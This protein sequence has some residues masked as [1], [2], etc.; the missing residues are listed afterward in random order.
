MA[1]FPSFLLLTPSSFNY[2]G[3]GSCPHKAVLADLDD[4]WDQLVPIFVRERLRTDFVRCI[5]FDPV[6][7]QRIDFLKEYF[8]TRHPSLTYAAPTDE[9]P[10]HA[11]TSRSFEVLLASQV[12]DHPTDDGFLEELSEKV[13]DVGGKLVVQDFSSGMSDQYLSDA[14]QNAFQK[15]HRPDTFKKSILFD[16]TYGEASCS[17]DMS[18]TRP[19]Y[20]RDG[21]FINFAQFKP[22]EMLAI[23]GYNEALDKLT[24]KLFMKKFKTVLDEHHGNYRRRFLGS[25]L[26]YKKPEYDDNSDAAAVMEV[27]QKELNK[28]FEVLLMMGVVTA[29]KHAEMDMLFTNYKKIDMYH[30]NNC[31]R[32]L[33]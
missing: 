15:T 14:F 22:K 3:I 4:A 21:N 29:E 28:V 2:V 6:F 11:W 9:S 31:V 19:V 24:K 12:F 1:S 8:A 7:D 27:L 17:T 5:H 20:D 16:M 26:L 32:K 13:L 33:V 18:T 30:W 23:W 10:Y 25:S